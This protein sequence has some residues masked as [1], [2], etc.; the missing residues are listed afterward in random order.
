[1]VQENISQEFRIKNIEKAR[2]YFVNS[3]LGGGDFLGVLF[4]VGGG[5]KLPHCLNLLELC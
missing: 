5:I 3:N 4:K 2:N 1:M